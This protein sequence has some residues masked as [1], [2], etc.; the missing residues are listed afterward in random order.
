MTEEATILLTYEYDWPGN[1]RELVNLLERVTNSI[2]P[3]TIGIHEILPHLDKPRAEELAL[4]PG[5]FK[6]VAADSERKALIQLLEDSGGSVRKAAES[7]G[8]HRTG[9]YKKLKKYNVHL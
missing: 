6:K 7:L 5:Y 4:G 1:I 8:V 2:E 9:L 3:D